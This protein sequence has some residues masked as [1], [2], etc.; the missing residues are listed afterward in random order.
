M[1]GFKDES[2]TSLYETDFF[3][4]TQ[5]QAGLIRSGQLDKVDLANVTE[6]IE[7]LGRAERSALMSSYRLICLHQL[8]RMFQA[9]RSDSRSWTQT[10]VRERNNVEANLEDNPGLKP[11]RQGLFARAYKHARREA[12]AETGMAPNGFPVHPP[13]TLQQIEDETYWADEGSSVGD[14]EPGRRQP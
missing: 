3:S 5:E 8:K 7:T 1:D 9:E 2:T 12:A 4:W 13:F 11:Q 14:D 6:E 10:I